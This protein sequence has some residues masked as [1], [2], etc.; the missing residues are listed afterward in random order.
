LNSD[1]QLGDNTT[2]ERSTPEAVTGG[3]TFRSLAAG[4]YY[5]CG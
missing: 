5:T 1:G 4:G 3:L 2:S